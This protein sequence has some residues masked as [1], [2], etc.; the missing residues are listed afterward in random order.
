MI[1]AALISHLALFGNLSADD[2]EALLSIK[3]TIR[4]LLRGEDVLV[5]GESPKESVIVLEGFLQ[6]YTLNAHGSRQI[7]SFYMPTDAPSLETIHIDYMDNNLGAVVSS[8]VGI[9]QHTELLRILDERP[10][11][12]SLVWRETL[13]Q[14][15]IFRMWLMRNSRSAALQKLAHLFCE[16]AT[17]HMAAGSMTADG[18]CALPITQT[19]LADALGLTPVHAN[20]T[21][22]LLRETGSVEWR[23]GGL[24]IHDWAR[25]QE[26]AEFDPTYLH[27]RK[28]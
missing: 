27:L 22:M 15:S 24:K 9:V 5:V 17:R 14:A 12:Q 28:R 3:G 20:R 19:D 25:L 13:V 18:S 16:I 26:I 8:K 7:H 4:H 2:R 10:T 11:V 21:L 23:S 6:R 1:G